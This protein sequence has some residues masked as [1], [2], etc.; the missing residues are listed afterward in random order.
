MKSKN[1]GG[2]GSDLTPGAIAK[3]IAPKVI[4]HVSAGRKRVIVCID[5]EQ[6]VEC[7]SDVA[8][9]VSS[10]LAKL[11]S[12]KC[13]GDVSIVVADRTFEAWLLADPDGLFRL[14]LFKKR[15]AAHSFEGSLGKGH[16]KGIVELGDALGRPYSKTKDGPILFAKLDLS[17]ARDHRGRGSRSLDKLLRELGV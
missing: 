1:L 2:V 5:R 13:N 6:R 14:N 11:I 7:A 12:G 8:A 17:R 10:A 9:R 15:P 16:K 3:R 4:A